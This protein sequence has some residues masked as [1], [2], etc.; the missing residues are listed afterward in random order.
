MRQH[1]TRARYC[2]DKCRCEPC[3]EANRLYARQRDRH[4]RRVAYGI[5]PERPAY[6]DATEARKH[7]LWLSKVGV[8]KRQV[9]ERTGISL[10][11]IYKL[12]RGVVTKCRPETANKILGIGRS[13]A[14]DGAY[15]DAT[16]IWK[17]IDELVRAGYTKTWI[18]AQIGSNAKTPALQLGR[19]R[20]SAIKARQIAELHER[21][22]FRAIEERRMVRER[23]AKYRA[24]KEQAA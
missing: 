9:A 20:V 4:L 24:G 10:S 18:A 5:E 1:G 8:G 3:T 2:V 21:T 23:Q 12:R 14:A 11:A 7:L 17:L 15:V 22:L 13:A 16:K 6:I 19:R